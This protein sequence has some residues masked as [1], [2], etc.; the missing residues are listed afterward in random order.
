MKP[1][2]SPLFQMTQGLP[3]T[4]S[5]HSVSYYVLYQKCQIW[6]FFLHSSLTSRVVE[7]AGP[8]HLRAFR[9]QVIFIVVSFAG[10]LL[11]SFED[12]C[13][14]SL[15]LTAWRIWTRSNYSLLPQDNATQPFRCS[16][17]NSRSGSDSKMRRFETT[18]VSSFSIT[19]LF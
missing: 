19:L 5:L 16:A 11:P 2:F 12:R 13:R 9:I 3:S 14:H 4:L 6:V 8:G 10:L 17:K 15:P 1:Q 18:V 7:Q